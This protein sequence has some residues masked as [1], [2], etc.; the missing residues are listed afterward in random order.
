M[1]S[2]P[3]AIDQIIDNVSQKM[4]TSNNRSSLARDFRS[5]T[6]WIRNQRTMYFKGKI[7]SHQYYDRVAAFATFIKS[8]IGI[9]NEITENILN[10]NYCPSCLNELND[11]SRKN[12]ACSSCHR[13]LALSSGQNIEIP[14]RM[15]FLF[16]LSF[17]FRI[18]YAPKKTFTFFRYGLSNWFHVLAIFLTSS[19]ILSFFTILLVPKFYYRVEKM[20][21]QWPDHQASV[22]MEGIV[23]YFILNIAIFLLYSGILYLFSRGASFDQSPMK[24]IQITSFVI[25]PRVMLLPLNGLLNVLLTDTQYH[26]NFDVAF[27]QVIWEVLN[28]QNYL[29]FLGIIL[30]P[31]SALLTCVLLF[32]AL[33]HSWEMSSDAAAGR[34]VILGVILFV[35]MFGFPIYL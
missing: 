28:L 14:P 1:Y 25:L 6:K 5:W 35:L 30:S 10:A 23:A 18:F 9:T 8:K 15:N 32:Y 29:G 4:G 13:R 19:V 11:K 34:A 22:I 26:L 3:L 16:S 33:K 17:F 20:I 21:I 7:A 27:N 24:T 31:F 12:M 2:D